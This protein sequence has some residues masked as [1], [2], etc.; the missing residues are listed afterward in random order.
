MIERTLEEIEAKLRQSTSIPTGNRDELLGLLATLKTEVTELAKTHEDQA[1]S[2]A[3]FAVV[4]TH[5]AIR[6]P[7][8][9]VLLRHSLDGLSASVT[10]FEKSHPELVEIVN[11]I[12]TTL[13]NL[14]I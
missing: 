2:I 11:T 14:G 1:Q 5:E 4:S 3:G 6:T 12:C 7:R 13:S 10:E 9:P 8:N